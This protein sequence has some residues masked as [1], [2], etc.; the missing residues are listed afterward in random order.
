[1]K[2][3][4]KTSEVRYRV[5]ES[6][7]YTTKIIAKINGTRTDKQVRVSP[8]KATN[9]ASVIRL[10]DWDKL[11]KSHDEARSFEIQ[12]IERIIDSAKYTVQMREEELQRARLDQFTWQEKEI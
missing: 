7:D 2:T 6:P 4:P 5:I 1:M 3:K 9:Y 10:D 11:A 8:S 12:R